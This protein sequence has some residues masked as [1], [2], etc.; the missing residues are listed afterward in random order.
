MQVKA[1]DC[2]GGTDFAMDPATD[3][4]YNWCYCTT[5]DTYLNMKD[6]SGIKGNCL[7]NDE[8]KALYPDNQYNCD[9]ALLAASDTGDNT[10]KIKLCAGANLSVIDP[11]VVC[12]KQ[13]EEAVEETP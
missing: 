3:T 5:A 2:A 8:C 6:D 7:T 1:E 9:S 4:T 10:K 11:R 13:V 12:T